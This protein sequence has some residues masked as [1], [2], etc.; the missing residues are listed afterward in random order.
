MI[1]F[2]PVSS[3]HLTGY[4]GDPSGRTDMRSRMTPEQIQHNCECFKKQMSKFIDFS[5]GKA[6]MVNNA[7]WLLDLNYVE[8][9][10]LSLIHI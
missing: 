9:L 10:R 5:E 6:L 4:I 8:V 2:P 7:D 3:T 1:C